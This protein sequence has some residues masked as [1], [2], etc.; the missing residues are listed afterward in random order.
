MEPLFTKWK[1][2]K[3]DVKRFLQVPGYPCSLFGSGS[4]LV[5]LAAFISDGSF[6]LQ[7][8]NTFVEGSCEH[9]SEASACSPGGIGSNRS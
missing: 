9:E 3:P 8:K 1:W 6:Y 5:M 2:K 7:D 4:L